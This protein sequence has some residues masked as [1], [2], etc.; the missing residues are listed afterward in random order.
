MKNC[1]FFETADV[2]LKNP[3]FRKDCTHRFLQRVALRKPINCNQLGIKVRL[4]KFIGFIQKR[5]ELYD[6]SERYKSAE[7]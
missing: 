4:V 1:T 3:S 2:L 7:T 5:N 6:S